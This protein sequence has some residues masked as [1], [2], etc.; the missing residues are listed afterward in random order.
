[1]VV[2]NK[3]K[4]VVTSRTRIYIGVEWSVRAKVVTGAVDEQ[5]E[6]KRVVPSLGEG[7]LIKR[8]TILGC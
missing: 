6:S 7:H 2:N 4:S 3:R 8:Q 5:G 1:M